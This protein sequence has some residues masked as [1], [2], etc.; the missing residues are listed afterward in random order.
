MIEITLRTS[1]IL[2]LAL[3]VVI[4]I[5]F[6]LLCFNNWSQKKTQFKYEQMKSHITN[7]LPTI[8]DGKRDRF[9]EK[10]RELFL[11]ILIEIQQN[12]S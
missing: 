12:L 1:L 9:I 5:I 10:N 8:T 11:D 4:L 3:S 7:V 2:A 6:L